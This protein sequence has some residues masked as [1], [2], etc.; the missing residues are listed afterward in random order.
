VVPVR[1]M[2]VAAACAVATLSAPSFAR[3]DATPATSY[4]FVQSWTNPALITANDDWSTVPSITGYLGDVDAGMPTDVDPRTR[5]DANVGAVDVIANQANP[6]TLTAGGVAEFDQLANPTVALQGSATADA[7][8]LVVA[9]DTTGRTNLNVAYEVRDVD[10]S[11]ENAAQQVALQYRVGSSGSWTNVT[12]GTNAYIADAT[13]ASTA[14]QVTS[15][16]AP[17]PAAAE[18]Q[19]LVQV[20]ILTTNAQTSD[21]WVGID[22][23]TITSSSSG[24]PTPTVACGATLTTS[25]GTAASRA[26][27]ATDPDGR[28]TSI[29]IDSISGSPPPGSI[30]VGSTTPASAAG[31]TASATVSVSD[32][33]PAGSY[34]VVVKAT[35]DD[36][37]PQSGQCTLTV[38]VQ[39]SASATKVSAIQGSGYASPMVNQ[40][41][42]IEG[43]VIGKD[44]EKGASV[45]TG[46]V[47]RIFAGDRGLYVQ[48]EPADQD[49]N[50]QT[51]EGI[52]VGFV[53]N[54]AAYPVGTR[55]RISGRVIEQFGQTQLN[56]TINTEP[57]SLGTASPGQTPA[58]TTIDPA[59]SRGQELVNSATSTTNGR[60]A[61]YET[62]EGML[63]RL[64]QGTAN[65]GGTNKFGELFMTPGPDRVRVLRNDDTAGPGG[66]PGDQVRSLV[67]ADGDA[68]AGNPANPLLAPQ[69]SSTVLKGD[70]FDRFTDV[71]GPLNFSFANYKIVVQPGALPTREA[72]PTPFPYQG[73][74]QAGAGQVRVASFNVE[75]FFPVGGGLDGRTIS[76]AEYTEKR[77]RI[78]DAVDRLLKRPDVVAVQEVV[79]LDVLRA[80]AEKL[81]GYTAFL[82]EGND[83]RGI[84][85]G[86]LVKDGVGV[87]NVRQLGKTAAN[88]TA[89][90]SGDIAGRLF[91]RPPLVAD[92]N[93]GGL[94]FTIFTN[95]FSSKRAPDACREA[96]AA[97]V[98]DQVKAL[99]AAGRQVVVTGDL[100]AFEDEG[101]LSV[102]QDGQTT[103][104]NQ[105]SRAPA[106]ERYSFQFSGRLQT[107]DHILVTDGLDSRVVDLR[108]AHFDNDYFERTP[109]DGQK[110]SDHDPPVLTLEA[111]AKTGG[112]GGQSTGGN[113][114]SGTQTPAGGE[115][116]PPPGGAGS[117]PSGAPGFPGRGSGVSLLKGG[118]TVDR[119][120]RLRLRVR[121]RNPFTVIAD[122][123]IETRGAKARAAAQPDRARAKIPARATRTV[124]VNLSRSAAARL[125]RSGRGGR[126]KV[127]ITVRLRAPDG[128]TR[129][130]AQTLP[131][132]MR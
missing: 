129:T 128:S 62:L 106:G 61:Y 36:S 111:P 64:A 77:D 37:T 127:S 93:A 84:D 42:T 13:S 104:T 23:I 70:L 51:S 73:V 3:A 63:V 43:V 31:G 71:A 4:P 46:N 76:Q 30:T 2:L 116:T 81:G 39:A 53:D 14:T 11:A 86:Y 125:R 19:A 119:T 122:V 131:V 22:D 121:N 26:V 87:G 103:L 34:G 67:A 101:A 55:V 52:F 83:D 102:L 21:E 47:L 50:A 74:P 100:N 78:A 60:R 126:A 85:V 38:V 117:T 59:Q 110:V 48:E 7:P 17:L 56:E 54:V 57:T 45:G 82:E 40:D 9:L 120:R 97:F 65:S 69:S 35:N 98:R 124:T 114:G 12:G 89:A 92:V 105:W 99:E 20:R 75:N 32:A 130:L 15:V 44:D 96:Q 58:A 112:S 28:V 6:S 88:P 1:L 79:N 8:S 24:S 72:G 5:A 18:S 49:A 10:G 132:R 91:D 94:E 107:L 25:P 80:V 29:A 41:V 109:P 66:A 113:G 123:R 33:V 108:Y 16:S 95:H 68:G 90:T 115:T 118:L 27:T